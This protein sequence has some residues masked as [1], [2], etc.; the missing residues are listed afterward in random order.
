VRP[1][2]RLVLALDVPS[3]DAARPLLAKVGAAVSCVKV[4]L[5]LFTAEGPRAV[6]AV[7]A[8]GAACFLDLKLHDIPA[9]VARA[10]EAAARLGV[11][12]LAVHASSGPAALAA[13][14][15]AVEGSKTRLLAVTAL[16]SLDANDLE[17]IG[18]GGTPEAVVRRLA[19]LALTQGIDGFVCAPAECAS[20]RAL[21]GKD[22][23]LVV[24][25]V[26]PRGSERGDQARVATPA[27]A[28][29]GGADLLVVGRPIRD[30]DD[31]LEAVRAIAREIEE[32]LGEAP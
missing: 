4:G 28:I 27:E 26:R 6:E 32:A 16:T 9:T 23:L 20:V 18:M 31:P 19:T 22:A 8:S 5:E 30:A 7:H 17:A 11:R 24:P 13:A 3:L 14:R 12:Y 10:C 15:R 1:S 25:G 21:A 2:D 29:R